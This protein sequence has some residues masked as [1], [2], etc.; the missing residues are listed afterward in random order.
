MFHPDTYGDLVCKPRRFEG[1]ANFFL[2]HP[3]IESIIN[4]FDV[5]SMTK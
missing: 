1:A 2:L 3:K 4:A 5:E